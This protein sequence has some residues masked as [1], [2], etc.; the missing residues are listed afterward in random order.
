MNR[1][2]AMRTTLAVFGLAIASQGLA[3]DTTSGAF[4]Q[5]RDRPA[6]CEEFDWSEQMLREYPRVVEACQEVVVVGDHAFARL[7]ADFVRV[8]SDGHVIFN[9]RDRRDRYVDELTLT[10]SPGQK[11]WINERPTEFRNLRTSDTINLYAAEGQYGFVTQPVVA[12]EQPAAVRAVAALPEPVPAYDRSTAVAQ[13]EPA[14]Q[15]LPQTAGFL[16]WIALAGMF[17]LAAGLGLGLRRGA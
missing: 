14:P 7:A 3:Q 13:V 8:H 4:P 15:M 11:A 17:S 2:I 12:R 9:V 6:S 5:A 1:S 16:P 10:P